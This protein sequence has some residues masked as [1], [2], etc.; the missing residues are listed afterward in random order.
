MFA[1]KHTRLC[2]WFFEVRDGYTEVT[3]SFR[4]GREGVGVVAGKF[5]IVDD[6]LRVTPAFDEMKRDGS[7]SLFFTV[8]IHIL[9][10]IRGAA[11]QVGAT[12]GRE[13]VV[14]MAGKQGVPEVVTHMRAGTLFG[15]NSC[16]QGFFNQIKN[17]ILVGRI[18]AASL[19]SGDSGELER[20]TQ[21]CSV[22]KQSLTGST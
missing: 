22:T 1:L 8:A 6:V 20:T 2:L 7:G 17:A 13:F 21:H 10:H 18:D 9:Q 5:S 11:M 15:D 14:E 19:H 4:V 16:L 3:F 12:S